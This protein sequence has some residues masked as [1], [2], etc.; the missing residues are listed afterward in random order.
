MARTAA[1]LSAA[2][3]REANWEARAAAARLAVEMAVAMGAEA[4]AAA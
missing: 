3:T 1:G 4:R 2:E